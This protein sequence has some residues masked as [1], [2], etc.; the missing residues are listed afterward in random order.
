M[1]DETADVATVVTASG[2]LTDTPTRKLD[3]AIRVPDR[4]VRSRSARLFSVLASA[5]K[6]PVLQPTAVHAVQHQIDDLVAQDRNEAIALIVEGI[7]IGY[8]PDVSRVRLA[9]RWRVYYQLLR[10]KAYDSTNAVRAAQAIVGD[11]LAPADVRLLVGLVHDLDVSALDADAAVLFGSTGATVPPGQRVEAAGRVAAALKTVGGRGIE[12]LETAVSAPT[13]LVGVSAVA[14]AM[15]AYEQPA[16]ARTVEL[17]PEMPVAFIDDLVDRNVRLSKPIFNGQL[18]LEGGMNIDLLTYLTAR[19]TPKELVDEQVAAL[20]FRAE[21]HRRCSIGTTVSDDLERL[22][23]D[24]QERD[25]RIIRA[26]RRNELPDEDPQDRDSLL[27]ELVRTMTARSWDQVGTSLLNDKSTW[28]A[29][30]RLGP[31]TGGPS[32][33]VQHTINDVA[34]LLAARSALFEWRWDEA[35]TIARDGLRWARH[36]QVRDELL[37]LVACSLWL[38]DEPAA[39]LSALE[40]ALEGDYTESL[41]TNASVVA[42]ELD[43]EDAARHLTRLAAEAPNPEMRCLAAERALLLWETDER[44][45]YEDSDE[46]LPHPIRDSLRQLVAQPMPDDRYARILRQLAIHDDEWLARQPDASFG[47]NV[48]SPIRRVYQAR[49]RGLDAFV[50]ALARELQQTSPPSVLRDERDVMVRA[51]VKVLLD[52]LSSMGSAALGMSIVESSLPMDDDDR[53]ALTSLTVLAVCANID[54]DEAEPNERFLSWMLNARGLLRSLNTEDRDRLTSVVDGASNELVRTIAMARSTQL[55]QGVN[56]FNRVASTIAGIR[57]RRLNTDAVKAALEPIRRFAIETKSALRQ[58][59]PLA[60]D[61]DLR[62]A[63]NQMLSR[64][65]ELERR[66]RTLV[67]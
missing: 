2:K 19:V 35:R 55:E 16:E 9:D 23:T 29:L 47:A 57:K 14:R 24:E 39:A 28:A 40:K 66:C 42:T 31:I 5:S 36:E 63:V 10:A 65:D 22:L 50:A 8:R 49:A 17:T 48:A 44:R 25:A 64:A 37:N 20:R 61:S 26:I 46:Q 67:Q 7:P 11:S 12:L 34:T 1:L 27:G 59:V 3:E 15:A 38:S 54:T 32:S 52:D 41:L 13:Q 6:H 4:R 45:L 58:I 30:A 51:V 62:S 53:V 60:S 43:F 18:Q 56:A 21:A 33:D